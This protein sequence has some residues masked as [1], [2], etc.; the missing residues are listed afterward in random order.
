MTPAAALHALC[1][2][3]PPALVERAGA[4]AKRA[5]KRR[6]VDPLLVAA[7]IRAESRC[8]PDA[9]NPRT[10]AAGL[11]QVL[12]VHWRGRWDPFDVDANVAEGVRL[13]ARYARRC[14]NVAGALSLYGGLGSCAPSA[15]S[16]K[17]L[18]LRARFAPK[19]AIAEGG[20]T[21]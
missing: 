8:D 13:F 5:E 14:G 6:R 20:S 11:L 9:V 3:S 1:P 12:P 2:W 19:L 18:G 21:P 15:W 16:A 7:M 10:G 17:V 4:A